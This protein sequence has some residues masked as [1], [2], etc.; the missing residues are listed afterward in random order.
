MNYTFFEISHNGK[1]Y[2]QALV[3]V[4]EVI[5]ELN[6]KNSNFIPVTANKPTK[7]VLLSIGTGRNGETQGVDANIAR[8]ISANNWIKVMSAG[9]A[10][11]AQHMNEYHLKAVFPDLPSSD[12]YHL[13]IEVHITAPIG[14]CI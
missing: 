14:C 2:V 7:I 1:L 10:M 5:Q 11:S 8:F 9:L 12:N 13:R 6:E 4:S 3:A